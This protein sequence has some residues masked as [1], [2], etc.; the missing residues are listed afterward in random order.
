M[1]AGRG[2]RAEGAASP[3][4]RRSPATTCPD[5]A[6]IPVPERRRP[7]TGETVVV[8]GA[9][10]HNLADIDVAFPLG[11]MIAV[12][13]VSGSGKSTLVNDILLRSLAHQ[14]HR[15]KAIPGRHRAGQRHRAS[16]QGGRRRPGTDRP[17]PP[18]QPRH[19]HRRLRPR[20]PALQPDPGGQGPRLPARAGSPSTCAAG[21]ARPAPATGRSRSRCTSSPT[22]TCPARSAT[23]PATTATRSTSTFRGKTIADVLDMSCEEALGVLRQ[24]APDRPAHADPGRRRP[25]LHPA[26]ASPRRPCRAARP[27]G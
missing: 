4:R 5:G 16:R 10:E 27:S 14:L 23:A 19:L 9:R 6:R 7:G 2:D 11:C 13:G 24:P 25:R 17:D 8:R 18:L 3:T 22:C 15:A 1:H 20:P 26:W 12:T 21:G